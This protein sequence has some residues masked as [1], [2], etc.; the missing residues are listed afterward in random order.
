MTT[1]DVVAE[2]TRELAPVV[3]EAGLLLEDVALT[4]PAKKHTLRVVLDLPDGPGGVDSDVLAEAS[5]AVSA[6]LDEIDSIIDGAYLLEVT[7]PGLSRPLTQ[8][9]HF[10]RAQGRLVEVT[11]TSKDK[12]TGRVLDADDDAV[13]LDVDGTPTRIPLTD[14]AN[15][16]IEVE[17]R[18]LDADA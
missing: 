3:S 16:R 8:P 10:R 15:G 4:G 9:R 1:I 7:T 17:F 13:E 6:K 2:L 5:R 12:V 11:L 14:L 18:K